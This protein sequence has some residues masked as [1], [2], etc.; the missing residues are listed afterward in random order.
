ML[1]IATV[2][3]SGG[4]YTPDWVTRLQRQVSAHAPPHKF[5]CLSDTE[6]A[7]IDC[8]PLAHDWP[9][10]WAKMCVFQVPGPCL[11]MDLDTLVVGPLDDIAAVAVGRGFTILRDFYRPDGLGSGLMAWSTCALTAHLYERFRADPAAGMNRAGGDQAFVEAYMPDDYVTRWQDV[12]P[13][14]VVSWKADRCEGGPPPNARI[15]AFH[16]RPKQPDLPAANWARR[17][18]EG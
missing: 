3:R 1:T 14:Q 16:G 5:I 9:G 6:I 11:Y 4:I 17:H 13:G 12:V 10:W 7:G 15:V 2:L 18:W 8:V